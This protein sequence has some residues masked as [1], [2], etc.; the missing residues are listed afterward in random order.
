MVE[1]VQSFIQALLSQKIAVRLDGNAMV[2]G[3]LISV[4]DH[5]NLLLSDCIYTAAGSKMNLSNLLV[6]GSSVV[7]MTQLHA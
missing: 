3:I 4:D 6:R 7:F 2:T 1:S 5:C